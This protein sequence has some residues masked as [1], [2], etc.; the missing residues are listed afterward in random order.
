MQKVERQ[1]IAGDNSELILISQ[2]MYDDV[3]VGSDDL[4][5]W[6]NIWVLLVFEVTKGT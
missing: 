2:F 4:F 5:F 6:R 1:T 3:R